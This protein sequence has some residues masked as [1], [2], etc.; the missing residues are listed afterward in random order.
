[1]SA[2]AYLVLTLLAAASMYLL[3]RGGRIYFKL[4]GKR[5][6]TCPENNQPAAVEV[7]AKRA[8]AESVAGVPHLRLAE[9][10][11]WPERQGCGQQCL[12]QIESAPADCLVRNIVAKWY[13]KKTCVYCGKRIQESDW[14]DQVPAL[15]GPD[16]KTVEWKQVSAEKL[17]EVLSRYLPV[18]WDC[19]IA[20]T[21]RREHPD[22]VVE[23]PWRWR[24]QG[25]TALPEE[26][27]KAGRAHF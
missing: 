19:H 7:D 27:K 18:C 17:P 26:S 9:C 22:L 8:F 15:L 24:S 11:R 13:A 10:S 12:K 4:R 5:L 23:R 6:V 20:E 3:V 21:F 25:E 14:L 2:L 16:R 1:M